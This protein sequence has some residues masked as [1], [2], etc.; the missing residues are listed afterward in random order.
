MRQMFGNYFGPHIRIYN[1][2]TKKEADVWFWKDGSTRELR[3]VTTS[4]TTLISQTFSEWLDTAVGAVSIWYDQSLNEYNGRSG[5]APTLVSSSI[6]FNGTSNYFYIERLHYKS[7]DTIPKFTVWTWFKTSFS[8]PGDL[9]DNWAFIDFDRS[10]WFD[11][12][13]NGDGYLG[14]SGID[15][16]NDYF[17][18]LGNSI[19]N[20]GVWNFGAVVYD[21]ASLTITFY[22]NGIV[23][24]TYTYASM[25][26]INNL[27]TRYGIIGDGSEAGSEDGKKN[28]FF[29]EGELRALAFI[30]LALTSAEI[31]SVYNSTI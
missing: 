25:N 30:P 10:E 28:G 1:E 18:I 31:L 7:G 17:D 27:T 22:V 11:F 20:N 6:Q 5:N 24:K 23:D 9:D 15:G 12:Y 14:F 4:G 19:L 21:S 26:P 3:E 16:I 2:V 8:S 29:Y 13:L